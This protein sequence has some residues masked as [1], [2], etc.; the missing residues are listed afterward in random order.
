MPFLAT[1]CFWI[2]AMT[3]AFINHR[4]AAKNV[5]FD[6]ILILQLWGNIFFSEVC[7]HVSKWGTRTNKFHGTPKFPPSHLAWCPLPIPA[8]ISLLHINS[9]QWAHWFF[10]P[11]PLVE[12]VHGRQLWGWLETCVHTFKMLYP[13]SDDVSTHASLSICMMNSCMNMTRR[14]PQQEFLSLQIA[15][16]VLPRHFLTLKNDHEAGAG[17]V[18]F[19]HVWYVRWN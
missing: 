10:H 7:A 6:S 1:F 5:I 2:K 13:L 11:I 3:L 8:I 14:Y 12:A 17:D 19:I 15:K 16:C 4:D 9:F 18:I